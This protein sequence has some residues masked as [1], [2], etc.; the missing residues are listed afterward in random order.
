MK[1]IMSLLLVLM[2]LAT[3]AIAMAEEQKTVTVGITASNEPAK[4]LLAAY[5]AET[6]VKV[7]MIE[8]VDSG[9]YRTKL[10]LMLQ[11][12]ETAPDVM[13]EDGFMVKSDAAA[14]ILKPLD[15]YLADWEDWNQYEGAMKEVG[16]GIDGKVYAVCMSTDVQA[17][18]YNADVFEAAGLPREWQPK[19]WDDVLEAAKTLKEANAD[20]PDFIPM[21]MWSTT[22][23]TERTSMRTFQVLYSGTEGKCY[24]YE[25]GKWIVDKTNMKKVLDFIDKAWNEYELCSYDVASTTDGDN[26]STT[27]LA[28]NNIGIYMTGSWIYANYI[29]GA[30]YEWEGIDNGALQF[31]F[32]PTYEGEG[33]TTMSGGWTWVVPTKAKNPDAGWELIKWL[34]S[35]ANSSQYAREDGSLPARND[36]WQHENWT[37]QPYYELQ[38]KFAESLSFTH[39]RDAVDNYNAVS[40]L[41][42]QMVEN[43]SFGLTSVE[44]ALEIFEEDLRATV[45]DDLVKVVE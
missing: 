37:S 12:D 38:S 31:T 21:F 17:L 20:N 16:L 23:K 14:G 32:F 43:V 1:K 5:E 18:W 26:V 7:E 8:I 25:E 42:A 28:N 44:E 34:S 13:Y 41:Y 35:A 36:A 24:D 45:G 19:N 39:F 40:G 22:A 10:A 2:L 33:Q 6:G 15:D 11:S 9:D 4:K 30:T 27:E 3:S 29:P